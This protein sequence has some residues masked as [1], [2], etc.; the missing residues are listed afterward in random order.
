MDRN[1]LIEL[2]SEGVQDIISRSPSWMLQWGILLIF[3]V[4]LVLLGASWFIK[5]PDVITASVPFIIVRIKLRGV[6][7]KGGRI[8]K[9][10]QSKLEKSARL[11]SH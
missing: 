4:F 8:V 3:F 9:G 7:N 2:R 11:K 5:Y 6:S 1:E 10:T